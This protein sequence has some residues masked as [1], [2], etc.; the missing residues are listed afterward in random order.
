MS[1]FLRAIKPTPLLN[2]PDFEKVFGSD[3]LPLDAQGLL[4]SVE[5]IALPQTKFQ[6]VRSVTPS[7]LEVKTH[8]YPLTPL[9][10]DT[11][12]VE[13][14]EASFPERVKI[15]PPKELILSRLQRA[16]GLPYI[17]GGNWSSGIPEILSYY[18]PKQVPPELQAT[19]TLKGVDCSGLL[20]EATE[21]FTPR[22][23][24]ELLVFG[25]N[26]P[27]ESFSLPEI[28]AK[29]KPLDILVWKGHVIILLNETTSIESLGGKGV[30][31]QNLAHRLSTLIPSTKFVIRRFIK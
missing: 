19:W 7:I 18:H 2:T 25:E 8:D 14:V 17:W 1:T 3:T 9:Y 22:N 12:F 26:I 29:V 27:F 15:L 5:M 13:D 30:I 10:L 6:K 11:R 20:Y 31:T 21:G 28:L 23:T 16:I 24:S 4:R